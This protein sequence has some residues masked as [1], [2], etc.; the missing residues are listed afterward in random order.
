MTWKLTWTVP[1]EELS[2]IKNFYEQYEDSPMVNRRRRKNIDRVGLEFSRDIF[3]KAML[4]CLATS[5]QRSGPDSKVACFLRLQ[6]FPITEEYCRANRRSL[7]KRLQAKLSKAGIRF[8]EQIAGFFTTNLERLTG[9][10]WQLLQE[11]RD[12]A[13]ADQADEEWER[14]MA[15]R[16][17]TEEG[18]QSFKLAGFGP[19]QARNLLQIIG[20][21][22][23]EIPLDSR[24]LKWL[25]QYGFPYPLAGGQLQH[26]ALYDILVDS[27]KEVSLQIGVYPCLLDAAIFASIDGDGWTEDKLVF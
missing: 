5:Q 16:I 15:R 3:L 19:K 23:Y 12:Y 22:R 6:P 25:D 10:H 20:V 1:E 26:P 4:C 14:G 21:S 7:T 18:N 17:S 27:I 9:G 13:T 8:S 24:L 11:L 2:I